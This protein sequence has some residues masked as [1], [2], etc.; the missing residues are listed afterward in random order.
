MT[1]PVKGRGETPRGTVLTF[2]MP[3]FSARKIRRL[4]DQGWLAF[5]TQGSHSKFSAGAYEGLLG[6]EFAKCQE[7]GI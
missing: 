2:R 1:P 3:S 5:V 7:A 4:F 6:R